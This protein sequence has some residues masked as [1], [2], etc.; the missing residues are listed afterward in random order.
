MSA[1]QEIRTGLQ[2]SIAALGTLIV[3]GLPSF[4]RRIGEL[5]DYRPR[6]ARCVTEFWIASNTAWGGWARADEGIISAA[7]NETSLGIGVMDQPQR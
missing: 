5:R 1:A 2:V 6:V 4:H 7:R 3:E